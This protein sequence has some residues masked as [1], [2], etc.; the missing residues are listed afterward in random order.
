MPCLLLHGLAG[1]PFEMRPL[2]VA[3]E[4]DGFTVDAAPLP[5]HGGDLAAGIHYNRLQAGGAG[6]NG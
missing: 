5:G 6:V 1:S 2:A 3:L 4:A